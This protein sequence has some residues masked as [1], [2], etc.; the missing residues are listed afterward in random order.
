[1]PLLGFPETT[2]HGSPRP[3]I[4]GAH[5]GK[6]LLLHGHQGAWRPARRPAAL[7]LCCGVLQMS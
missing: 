5:A 6:A 7:S 3:R 1:M 4:L 2:V